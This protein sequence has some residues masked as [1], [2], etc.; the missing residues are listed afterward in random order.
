MKEELEQRLLLTS[1]EAA[2]VLAISQRTLFTLTK[3]GKLA[4]VRIGSGVRYLLSDLTKF[5]EAQRT[6][7]LE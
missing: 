4:V 5:V 2:K 7:A 3:A 6:Q 1:R